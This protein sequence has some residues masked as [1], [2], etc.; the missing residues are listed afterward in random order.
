MS[1]LI[2]FKCG[3]GCTHCHASIKEVEEGKKIVQKGTTHPHKNSL[4]WPVTLLGVQ[5]KSL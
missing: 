2:A 3:Q 1:L 4:E 5:Y